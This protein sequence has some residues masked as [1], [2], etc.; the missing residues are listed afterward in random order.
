MDQDFV[1]AAQQALDEKK[2]GYRII[3]PAAKT[4]SDSMRTT[5]PPQSDTPDIDALIRKHSES[6]KSDANP[7]SD[8]GTGDEDFEFFTGK[9]K[10]GIPGDQPKDADQIIR[11]ERGGLSND[12][13]APFEEG[14]VYSPQKNKI[15]GWK[16]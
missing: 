14:A 13:K 16:G 9:K 10:A 7:G 4:A 3:V 12:E 6:V 11:I 2:A 1:N 5:L 8:K 15:T